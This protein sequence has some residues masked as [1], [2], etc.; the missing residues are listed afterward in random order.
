MGYPHHVAV[1]V[2]VK[3]DE[4]FSGR[5]RGHICHCANCRKVAGGICTAPVPHSDPRLETQADC[6]LC[7]LVGT[8]LLIEESKVEFS[9]GKD[10]LKVYAV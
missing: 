10:G 5:R 2:R 7:C 4:L 3:D 9:N 6:H 1:K 8:N